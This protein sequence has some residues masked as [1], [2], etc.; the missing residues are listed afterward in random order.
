[1]LFVGR[2]PDSDFSG[3]LQL[4]QVDDA[5]VAP[6]RRTMQAFF[7]S[8]V[9]TTPVIPLPPGTVASTFWQEASMTEIVR[10]ARLG[11]GHQAGQDA[12]CESE[13]P[14]TLS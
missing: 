12:A 14:P 13:D 4:L 10:S 1:M 8:V 3:H 7:E 5:N 6:S 11:I 2:A 9:T